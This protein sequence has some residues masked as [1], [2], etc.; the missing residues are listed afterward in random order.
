[1][2]G[3]R[4]CGGFFGVFKMCKPVDNVYYQGLVVYIL[5]VFDLFTDIGFV[6]NVQDTVNTTTTF[7][8]VIAVAAPAFVAAPYLVNLYLAFTFKRKFGRGVHKNKYTFQWF[9]RHHNAFAAMVALSGGSYAALNLASSRLF[10]MDVFD[11]GLTVRTVAEFKYISIYCNV[12]LQNVPNLIIQSIFF[13]SSSEISIPL[14]LAVSSSF[15]QITSVFGFSLGS[16]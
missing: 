14:I 2:H 13:V 1:M 9:Q 4:K 15:A 8:F 7:G 16:F 11:S 12:L 6:L 10:G 3:Q 5:Q